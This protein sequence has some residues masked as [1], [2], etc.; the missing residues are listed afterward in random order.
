MKTLLTITSNCALAANISMNVN[1]TYELDGGLCK[2]I[3]KYDP[4]QQPSEIWPGLSAGYILGLS[5]R[6]GWILPRLPD[7]TLPYAS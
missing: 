5:L 3:R 2:A 1:A 4:F 6:N 7:I